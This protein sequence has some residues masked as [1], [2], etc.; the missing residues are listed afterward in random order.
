M[1]GLASF[2]EGK[3]LF[4]RYLPTDL[5]MRD[6]GAARES[7]LLT[8]LSCWLDFLTAAMPLTPKNACYIFVMY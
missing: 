2:T 7:F 8:L 3:G 1:K 4:E 5:T 6:P